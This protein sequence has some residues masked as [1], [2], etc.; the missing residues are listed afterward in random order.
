MEFVRQPY[1]FWLKQESWGKKAGAS[2]NYICGKFV[3]M[4]VKAKF[5]RTPFINNSANEFLSVIH[6]NAEA[7]FGKDSFLFMTGSRHQA[8]RGSFIKLFTKKAISVYLSI[9]EEKVKQDVEKWKQNRAEIDLRRHLQDLNASTSQTAFV[10]PYIE[11]TEHFQGLMRIMGNAFVSWPIS[12]P[13]SAVWKTRRARIEVENMLME[14]VRLSKINIQ[15]G[16]PPR[17]L[18]DFWSEVVLGDVRKA[19]QIGERSLRS[20]PI[21]T[22]W[23]SLSWISFLLHRMLPRHLCLKPWL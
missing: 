19:E 21:T 18:L 9:Q 4:L 7:V 15:E 13:G 12:F 2:W 3:I 11:D 10:G 17:C 20:M 6:P 5:A 8:L 22:R 16:K 14:A 1:R 23:L